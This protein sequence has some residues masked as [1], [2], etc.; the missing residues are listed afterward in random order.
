MEL[1]F[2]WQDE[3][4]LSHIVKKNHLKPIVDAFIANGDRY[5]LL[6]SAVL[7]LFEYIRKVLLSFS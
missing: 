6:N 1:V 7:D 3:Q 4:L 2:V 5:N